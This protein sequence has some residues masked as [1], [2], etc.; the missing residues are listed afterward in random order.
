MPTADSEDMMTIT[1][2]TWLQFCNEAGLVD[3]TQKGCSGVDLQVGEESVK[4]GLHSYIH[5]RGFGGV[6]LQVEDAVSRRQLWPY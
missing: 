6:D 4:Q 3:V 5:R 1:L 2:N